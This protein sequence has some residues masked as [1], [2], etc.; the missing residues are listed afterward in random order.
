[1]FTLNLLQPNASKD[2]KDNVHLNLLHP[3]AYQDNEG[4]DLFTLVA[5]TC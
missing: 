5:T 1:M 4:N 2:N 3:D